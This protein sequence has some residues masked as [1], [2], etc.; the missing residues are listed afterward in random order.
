VRVLFFGRVADQ[1]GRERQV[2]LPAAGCTIAELRRL[3][4]ADVLGLPGIRASI[5]RQVVGEDA[6]I[7]PGAEVAF[8]SVFSGG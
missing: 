1:L 8:F 2:E 3:I 5:D 6:F 4:A 7:R